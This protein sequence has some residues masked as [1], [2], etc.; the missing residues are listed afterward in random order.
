MFS[1]GKIRAAVCQNLQIH[2]Y[3]EILNLSFFVG[4]TH[5]KKSVWYLNKA[6]HA[7]AGT[8]HYLQYCL[9]VLSQWDFTRCFVFQKLHLKKTTLPPHKLYFLQST[10]CL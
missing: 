2:E 10:L 1:A 6:A 3:K 7:E 4:I 8:Y 5:R 9:A